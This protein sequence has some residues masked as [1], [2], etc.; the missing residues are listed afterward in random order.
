MTLTNATNG[1]TTMATTNSET[2]AAAREARRGFP[3]LCCLKCGEVDVVTVR[4]EDVSFLCESCGEP[5]A[6]QDVRE[7]IAGWERVLEWIS[8]APTK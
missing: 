6:A 5:F 2:R 7:M 4:L 8:L 3:G 1:S